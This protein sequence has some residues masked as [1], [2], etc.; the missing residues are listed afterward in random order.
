M[1]K[2]T[3][4]VLCGSES[5]GKT[6]Y[7]NRLINP[8]PQT[9][10][11]TC[12]PT[13]EDFYMVNVETDRGVKELV[14]IIDTSGSAWSKQQPGFPSHYFN[15]ADGFIIFYDSCNLKSFKCV[16]TIKKELDKV[17]DKKDVHVV[18]VATKTDLMTS[19]ETK[20]DSKLVN[21]W[22][23][24]EKLKRFEVSI[25][26]KRSSLCQVLMYLVN[27]MNQPP[28]KTTLLGSRRLLKQQSSDA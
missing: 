16:E 24:K 13:I 28:Q 15:F 11:D 1:G 5:V 9:G 7:V 18:L 27:K 6:S 22:T 17:R 4:V 8:Q 12:Y 3:R 20:I 23:T 14:K 10:D 2:I 25:Y 26:N 21:S 19:S